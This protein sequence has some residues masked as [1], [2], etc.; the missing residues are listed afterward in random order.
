MA[1]PNDTPNYEHVLDQFMRLY[2]R[3]ESMPRMVHVLC[4]Y[5]AWVRRGLC[6]IRD[7]RA[8]I[9]PL[10]HNRI[11]RI[12]IGAVML[13]A[14]KGLP[15][16][17][18]ILK[19]RK[20]GASTL[21]QTILVFICQHY[22][23][24][25]ALML[26]HVPTSTREI[27]HIAK[28]VIEH[29]PAN[30]QPFELWLKFPETKSRY[31][32]HTAGGAN[33][34][35]A[36]TPTM[37][38]LSEVALYERNKANTLVSAT[39]SVP[40]ETNT[41][42]VW[43]STARGRE[44][45]FELFDAARNDPDHPYVAVFVP[46]FLDDRL[47]SVPPQYFTMDAD[48]LVIYRIAHDDYGIELGADAFQ[49]RRNEIKATIGG[50]SVFRQEHP[51]TPEEAIQG[52]ADL[53]LSDMRGCIVDELPFNPAMLERSA[54]TGG[55][56]YG[57]LDATVIIT[58]A[59]VDQVLTILEVYRATGS[60]AAEHAQHCW[61]GHTYWID[62]SEVQG[63]Q[64]MLAVLKG[65]MADTRIVSAPRKKSGRM[66]GFVQGELEMVQRIMHEGRLKI[67]RSAAEQLVLEADNYFW[68]PKSGQPDD[69]RTENCGHF[70]TMDALR[71]LV[72]GVERH[73]IVGATVSEP[74]LSRR[75]EFRI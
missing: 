66:T 26:A 50:I 69:R 6:M 3:K 74:R 23:N 64:E 57:Y 75:M 27:F 67:L 49:W 12:L 31:W 38:H 63:R 11:Q 65:G 73:G 41:I 46:W 18:I 2:H 13:Q 39:K 40:N 68:N 22:P 36:G 21:W 9:V 35:A 47:V 30:S 4:S 59:Y 45:F 58:A 1:T 16:R 34:G 52:S 51:S 61:E 10:A 44:E 56:D 55:I 37:L 29:Y 19:A 62:P 70:D 43:E 42:I 60:L 20:G 7:Q 5:V 24:Q 17:I 8:E 14:A 72:M 54:L 71:Y 33:V 53:I 28:T 15:I 32:C 25:I 48:E